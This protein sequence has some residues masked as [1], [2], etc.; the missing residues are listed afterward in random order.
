MATPKKKTNY[1]GYDLDWLEQQYKQLKNW[2]EDKLNGGIEDRIEMLESTRGNPI[3]KLI[4]SEETQ[5]KCLRDTLK[6]LPSMLLEINRLRK[7]ADEEDS[8]ETTVRGGHDIPGFMEDAE[9]D[10]EPAP[11]KEKP[12]KENLK[13]ETI[14]KQSP[15][16]LPAPVPN[17]A[18]NEDDFED[19]DDGDFEDP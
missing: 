16:A 1:I 11:I 19:D 9:D 5:I 6:E 4:A 17:S 18:Y 12:V 10:D 7:I 3:M 13:K 14:K 8:T 2:C 15:Q